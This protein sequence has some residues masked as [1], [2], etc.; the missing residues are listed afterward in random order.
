MAVAVVTDSTADLGALAQEHGIAVVPLTVSF[1]A[2]RYRDGVD[3]TDR[4]FYDRLRR[5]SNHPVTSQPTPAVFADTYR[6][7]LNAG[8]SHVVSLHLASALS[9][10][11]NSARIAAN[12]VAPDRISVIDTR[13]VSAGLGMLAIGAAQEARAGRPVDEIIQRV[14]RDAAALELYAAI[15]TLTYLAKG[16]RIG[17]LSGLLGNVL[18]IVP[19]V[20]LADGEVTEYARVRTFV[21]A[22][23]RLVEIVVRRIPSKGTARCAVMH[24]VAPD[25]AEKIEARVREAVQPKS[26]FACCA[27]PTVGAHA[28]PGAVGVFFIP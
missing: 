23:D 6:G 15:P 11:C 13:S 14:R 1:G 24:S 25:L 12:E 16:G 20:T 28:G 21:R 17:R 2:E 7:L 22:V 19:I 3:L 8:T 26:M 9:G 5:D 4:Q 10:T 27:G 18:K